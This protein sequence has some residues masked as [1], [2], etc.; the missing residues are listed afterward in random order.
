MNG[1]SGSLD[2]GTDLSFFKGTT[3]TQIC[4][5]SN[6]L[7]LNFDGPPIRLMMQS[8]FGTKVVGH[9][10]KLHALTDGHL[11]R[12]FLDREV[13]RALWGERGTLVL[14]FTGGDQLLIFD[15]SDDVE[16]YTISHLGQ[17]IVV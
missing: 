2:L 5:G 11:L 17:T 4:L 9:E 16:S 14:T 8:D 3:L 13:A 7:G 6:A 1:R 10:R 15:D 12:N